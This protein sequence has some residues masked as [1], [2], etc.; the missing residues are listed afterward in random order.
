MCSVRLYVRVLHYMF[1]VSDS[2]LFTNFRDS[3]LSNSCFISY[4][5]LCC[6]YKEAKE[7]M[8]ALRLFPSSQEE[9]ITKVQEFSNF[10]GPVRHVMDDMLLLYMECLLELYQEKRQ[11]TQ[12]FSQYQHVLQ[13]L[14]RDASLLVSFAGQVQKKLT[15]PDTAH[16]LMDFQTR[17]STDDGY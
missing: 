13:D 6:R 8:M 2:I 17:M 5:L 11:D 7:Y 4:L 1:H 14:R 9:K 16:R 12:H 3:N 15:R 10:E